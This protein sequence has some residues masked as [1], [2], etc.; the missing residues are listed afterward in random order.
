MLASDIELP[1]G[2]QRIQNW[3]LES[4]GVRTNFHLQKTPH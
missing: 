2:A 1:T 3:D 4:T